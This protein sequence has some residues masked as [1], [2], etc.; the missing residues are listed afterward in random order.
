MWNATHWCETSRIVKYGVKWSWGD[1]LCRVNGTLVHEL[2][3][4]PTYLQ[5][6]VLELK[7]W[8]PTRDQG[9]SIQLNKC[10]VDP[11]FFQTFQCRT[12]FI[13]AFCKICELNTEHEIVFVVCNVYLLALDNILKGKLYWRPIAVFGF[14]EQFQVHKWVRSSYK[15]RK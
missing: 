7:L 13:F 12:M 5:N 9:I 11:C 15:T 1:T 6:M 8:T 2:S 3:H 10:K 14:L 4:G